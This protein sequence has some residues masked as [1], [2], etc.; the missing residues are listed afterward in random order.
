[1]QQLILFFTT[2]GSVFLL[3]FLQ[4]ICGFL[5]FNFNGTT[6]KAV[7]LSSAGVVS[8][9][10]LEL[11]NKFGSYWN[12]GAVN[13]SLAKENARLKMQFPNAKYQSNI[14]TQAVKDSVLLQQ[15][16][17]TSAKIVNNNLHHSNNYITLNR[18][19]NHNIKS[20]AGVVSATTQ[21]VV[22]IIKKVSNNYSVAMSIFH[23]E[24]RISAKIQK[25]D[26]FGVL[27]WNGKEMTHLDL[28]A[29]PKHAPIQKGDTIVTSGYSNLFPEGIFIGVVDTFFV[30]KS[31]NFFTAKVRLAADVTTTQQVYI[32]TDLMREEKK[33]LEEAVIYE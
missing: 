15:Y 16:I 4:A 13:D 6:E 21:G 11:A 31:S 9:N 32:V 10:L 33:A 27:V 7:F 20:N 19:S 3:V 26:H 18:G 1:M 17:Y 28:E 24:T 30:V 23:K 29:L 5:Y 25:N 8:S 14:E 22:G 12:L 2:Y